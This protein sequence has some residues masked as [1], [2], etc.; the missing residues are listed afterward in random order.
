MRHFPFTVAALVVASTF[1]SAQSIPSQEKN[2]MNVKRLTTVLL[3]KDIEPV[4][5]FWVDRLGFTKT[6]EVPDGNKLG[7]VAFQKGA[8][9]VMYQTYASVEKDAP[10]EVAATAGKGP[11]YLYMEVDN[12]DAVLAAMKDVKLVMPVRTAFYGMREFSVQDPGGHFITFAQAV[13]PPKH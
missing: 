13:P 9:E 8:A 11:S 2:P 10:K 12:L 1:F 3:V 7:F 5:P 4:I 6:I